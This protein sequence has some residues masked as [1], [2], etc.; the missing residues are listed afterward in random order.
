MR[1]QAAPLVGPIFGTFGS[2]TRFKLG[3]VGEVAKNDV[4][5]VGLA[6]HV[7]PCVDGQLT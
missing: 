6:D 5:E 2:K 3:V 4:R 1:T 7:M